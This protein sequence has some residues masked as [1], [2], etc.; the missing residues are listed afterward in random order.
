MT[1]PALELR[2]I[3]GN[4]V[5]LAEAAQPRQLALGELPGGGGASVAQLGHR[6]FPFK[7]LPRLPVADRAH[8]RQRGAQAVAAAQ[9]THLI[10]Q[11]AGQHRLEAL[12]NAAMER[13]AILRNQR[14][15]LQL[16]G[17]LGTLAALQGTQW[18]A[19]EPP[20]LE[21]ALDA[22]GVARR[23]AACRRRIDGL[24]LRMQRWPAALGRLRID[25]DADIGVLPRSCIALTAAIASARQRPVE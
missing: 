25:S 10:D 22:L 2:R 13:V 5:D 19:G 11:P 1:H 24:Q 23:D 7:A 21:C 8:A 4:R 6:E 14:K 20:N 16:E 12:G 15:G 17:Q 9:L 18:L 3:G